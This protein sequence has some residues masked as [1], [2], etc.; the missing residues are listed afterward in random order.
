MKYTFSAAIEI[1]GVNPYVSIPE[2]MLQAIFVES[3]KSKGTIAI[4]GILNK[5]PFTQTL[6]KF[7]GKWR[8]YINLSML[9]KSTQRIGETISIAFELDF[10][11][12]SIPMFPK[13]QLALQTNNEARKKFESLSPS[14]QKEINRYLHR[15]KSE[16]SIEQNIHK[17][18]AHLTGNGAFAGRK[19]PE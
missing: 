18:I 12:R 9:P 13:L 10:D 15:L 19:H 16:Q 14:R 11:D 8:L 17:V 5:K 7:Q 4:K 2:D 3:G 6:V 1:I